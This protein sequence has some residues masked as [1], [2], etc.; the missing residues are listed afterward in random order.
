MNHKVTIFHRQNGD[1]FHNFDPEHDGLE[2]AYSYLA[3]ETEVGLETIFRQNNAVDG[4]E[5]NCQFEKRSLS[6][7]DVVQISPLPEEPRLGA[8]FHAVAGIGFDEITELD[9]VRAV[10]HYGNVWPTPA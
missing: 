9:L 6:V 7:G 3:D 2:F 8:K 1:F 5:Y 4:S 10:A